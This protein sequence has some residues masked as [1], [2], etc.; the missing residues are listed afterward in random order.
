AAAAALSDAAL[1]SA[2]A[3][4]LSPQAFSASANAAAKNS[5]KLIHGVPLLVYEGW[6]FNSRIFG[7]ENRLPQTADSSVSAGQRRCNRLR[8]VSTKT[9]DLHVSKHARCAFAPAL[10]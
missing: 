4:P 9:M 8:N 10:K 6:K 5:Y 7:G 2:A 3:L 1:A